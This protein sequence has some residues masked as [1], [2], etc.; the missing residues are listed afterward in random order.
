GESGNKRYK[1]FWKY[2]VTTDSWTQIANFNGG[3]R[4]RATAF[5]IGNKG[6]IG[7]GRDS[8]NSNFL[9]DFW[10]LTVP[11]NTSSCTVTLWEEDFDNYALNSYP[12][13]WANLGNG[14]NSKVTNRDFTSSPYSCLVQ[15]SGNCWEGSI[16]RS[17]DTSYNHYQFEVSY[18]FDQGSV[19]CHPTLGK[20]LLVSHANS[21][22]NRKN[23]SLFRFSTNQ[24]ILVGEARKNVGSF[25]Q[26]QWLN[27]KVNYQVNANNVHMAYYV[28]GTLKHDTTTSKINGE[29]QLRF[30][31]LT[32]GDVDIL[33][34]DVK[35]SRYTC[36]QDSLPGINPSPGTVSSNKGWSHAFGNLKR[37]LHHAPQTSK[38]T[39]D[40]LIQK[41]STSDSF[42]DNWLLS[43]DINGNGKLEVVYA[44]GS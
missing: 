43:G 34:D 36:P 32:S 14:N 31:G 16:W 29:D 24:E 3:K 27:L 7:T 19:G 37:N 33:Y 26:G 28:N 8:T 44:N 40:S 5:S 10:Q 18:Q 2:N 6:Y 41:F 4:S 15:G 12:S 20:I 13:P 22:N 30:I 23:R 38:T 25:N 21:F 35:V 17:Y 11:N 1:D 9:Q 42:Q 39:K